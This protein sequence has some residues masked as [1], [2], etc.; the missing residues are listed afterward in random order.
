MLCRTALG[1]AFAL[2]IGLAPRAH[3][4]ADDEAAE[5]APAAAAPAAAADAADSADAPAP[6]HH[7]RHK[8]GHR[9]RFSGR[10]VPEDQLR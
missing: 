2:L 1:A 10:V 9:F 4:E 3:A 6:K 8:K 7:R 5:T